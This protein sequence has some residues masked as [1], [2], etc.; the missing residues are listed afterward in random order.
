MTLRARWV[1]LRA[2]WL[3]RATDK[4]GEG[5]VGVVGVSQSRPLSDGRGIL[6]AILDSGV[7]PGAA[8]LQ[9]C[10]ISPHFL[11]N[12]INQQLLLSI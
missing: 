12:K 8:G 9:V 6:I 10:Q 11:F 5:V 7:D 2:R 4:A 3:G 1:T